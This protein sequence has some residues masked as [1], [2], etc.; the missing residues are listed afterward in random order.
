MATKK[1]WKDLWRP[2]PP[3][4]LESV[5]FTSRASPS[6][7]LYPRTLLPQVPPSLSLI[8]YLLEAPPHFRPQLKLTCPPNPYIP[9]TSP[10]GSPRYP[11]SRS[12]PS[13]A[14]NPLVLLS[15]RL[16]RVPSP[17]CEGTSQRQGPG[18]SLGI[19]PS[20]WPSEARLA[21]HT[22]R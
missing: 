7:V 15:K 14:R 18:F 1:G 21:D 8:L 22:G 12:R 11:R 19:S 4:V 20:Q 6:A 17:H 3:P 13:Q 16:T 10:C 2:G 5:P 9:S